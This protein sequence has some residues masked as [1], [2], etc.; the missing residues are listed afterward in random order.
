MELMELSKAIEEAKASYE[1]SKTEEEAAYY[2][3][4]LEDLRDEK[5]EILKKK[6]IGVVKQ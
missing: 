3:A 4:I 2:K 6:L 5:Q 1:L